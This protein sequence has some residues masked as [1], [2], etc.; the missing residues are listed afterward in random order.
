MSKFIIV[1]IRKTQNFLT[2]RLSKSIAVYTNIGIYIGDILRFF[3][4]KIMVLN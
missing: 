3:V 4:K 2:A 1:N